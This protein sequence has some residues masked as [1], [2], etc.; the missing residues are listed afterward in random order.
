MDL[1]SD[2]PVR[3]TQYPVPYAMQASLKEELQQMEEMGADQA[4][5]CTEP[6]LRGRILVHGDAF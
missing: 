1:T 5:F 2:K 3:Q 4:A 6:W